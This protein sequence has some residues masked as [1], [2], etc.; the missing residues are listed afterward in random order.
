MGL[1][2]RDSRA[3]ITYRL[4]AVL[5]QDEETAVR[6]GTATVTPHLI[7]SREV[8]KSGKHVEIMLLYKDEV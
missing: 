4:R 7:A 1:V 3:A 5:L 6:G 8:G 2:L